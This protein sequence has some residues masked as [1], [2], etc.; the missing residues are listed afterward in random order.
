[1]ASDQAARGANNFDIPPR[2]LRFSGRFS[3]LRVNI[4]HLRE[5]A[6][7]KWPAERYEVGT[8][9]CGKHQQWRIAMA[10]S[11]PLRNGTAGGA[12]ALTTRALRQ[13][14]RDIS[15]ENLGA[16]KGLTA[17]GQQRVSVQASVEA[18]RRGTDNQYEVITKLRVASK[19]ESSGD[20][21][22]LLEIEY[23]GL[24]EVTGLTEDQLEPYLHVECPRMTFP[25]LRRIVAQVTQDGSLQPLILDTIDFA[26]IYRKAQVRDAQAG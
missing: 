14:V 4:G 13:Y 24:F 8:H 21:T 20:A 6:V 2:L 17:S 19:M 22:F 25:F 23:A 10:E 26:S 11:S 3:S 1:M 7:E 16:Q 5:S 12:P 18:H 9:E 15:F